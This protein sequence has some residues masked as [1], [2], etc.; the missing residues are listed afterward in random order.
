MAHIVPTGTPVNDAERLVVAHLRDHGPRNWTVLPNVE[1]QRQGDRYE[2]DLVVVTEQAVCL[3]D[4]KGTRGRIEVSGRRWYP[5]GRDGFP[6]PLGKLRHHARAV[7]GLISTGS[8][9]DGCPGLKKLYVDQLIVLTAGDAV[10]DDP[11]GTDAR[12][13]TSLERLVPV[14]ADPYRVPRRFSGTGPLPVE[15]VLA[16]LNAAVRPRNGPLR[17]GGWEVVERLGEGDQVAEYRARNAYLPG[18]TATRLLRVYRADPYL[19]SD[20][21]RRAQLLRIGNAYESLSQLP[22]HPNVVGAHDFFGTED[23]SRYVLVLDDPAASTLRY[24]LSEPEAEQPLAADPLGDRVV[25]SVEL[26]RGVLRGL[27]HAHGH[28]VLHRA[29]SPATILV[30]PAGRPMLTGF[31]Y[32]KPRPSREHTVAWELPDATDPSYAA[33]ETGLRPDQA[34]AASD[35]Y[36]AG[37]VFAELLLGRPPFPSLLEQHERDCQLPLDA[38]RAA[39][40]GPELAAWLQWLC[41][42]DPASR[43]TAREALWGLDSAGRVERPR[44]YRSAEPGPVRS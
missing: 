37:A 34:S 18:S 28:G 12:D 42:A 14:L 11:G 21:D 17:F 4:V 13:V 29:V 39:G 25:H 32:A 5:E 1:I 19:T 3:L 23:E 27:A 26:A 9:R 36:S 15:P 6:S 43:P 10:L 30:D 16:A 33:P 24:R 38:L 44:V 35:V 22:Q 8:R 31:D 2:I 41:A 20:A 7:K 40:A